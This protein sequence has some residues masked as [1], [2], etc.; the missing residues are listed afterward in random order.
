MQDMTRKLRYLFLLLLLGVTGNAFAQVGELYGTILDA[1]KQPA[2]GAIITVEQGGINKGG[3]PADIDGNFSIKP[4]QAGRYDVKVQYAGHQTVTTQGVV[5]NADHATKLSLNLQSSTT[6]KEVVVKYVRPIIDV[7][8]PGANNI[9]DRETIKN[10]PTRNTA[11]IAATSTGVYQAKS[12]AGLSIAG[13]R[14]QGTLYVIDGVQVNG[15]NFINQAPDVI[16]QMEVLTS[17]IPA[18]YGDASGGVIKITTRGV[19]KEIRGGVTAEHS[20]DGYDNNYVAFNLSGPFATRKVNDIKKPI[21]GFFLAGDYRQYKDNDPSYEKNYV[22]KGDKLADLQQHPL[23]AVSSPTGIPVLNPAADYITTGDMEQQKARVNASG[24]RATLTGKLDYE[25]TP[26]TNITAGGSFAY[27][28]AYNYNRYYTMFAPDAISKGNSYT[29]RGYVRFTQRLGKPATGSTDN[30]NKI[31]NAYYSVQA[32]YQRDYTSSEDPNH[33]RNAFDYGYVGKFVENVTPQYAPGYDTATSPDRYGI[34]LLGYQADGVSFTPSNVNPYLSNYTSQYYALGGANPPSLANIPSN[35]AY[36]RNGDAPLPVYSLWGNVGSYISGYSYARADQFSLSVDASFDYKHNKTTHAIEFGLY[37]QQRAERSYGYGGNIWAVM[38]QLTSAAVNNNLD[39]SNPIFVVNGQHY[40]KADVNNGVVVPGP[41]DTILYNRA[42]NGS[43]SIN[44]GFDYNLRKKLG[45]DVHG[46]DYIQPDAM[47]PSMFSLGMFT[48]DELLNSGKSLV[49]YYGYDYTGNILNGQVNFNDFWKAKDANGMYTRPIGAYRPNY[50]AGYISDYI[51]FKDISLT[52]GVRIERFDNN[53]KVLKDPY[54]LYPT[55]NVGQVLAGTGINGSPSP[56]IGSSAPGG[57]G[58]GYVVYVDDNSSSKPTV[59]GYR[60]GDTWYD[61]S[62][63]E[64]S[65]PTILKNESGRD[66]QPYLQKTATGGVAPKITDN[67]FDPTGSFT[68]YTPQVNVMPRISFSFPINDVGQ[69]YAHY[70]VIMQRPKPGLNGTLSGVGAYASPV[71]YFYLQQNAANIIGN[72][73]LKP[74]KLIDYEVGFQQKL[75]DI[76]AITLNAFYKERQDQIQVRP[77]LYAY[78][79]TYYTY[80]NRD[81]S[82]SKGLGVK[83]E[84]RRTNHLAMTLSYTLQFAEGTGSSAASANGGNAGTVSSG[85]LLQNLISAQLPNLMFVTPLDYDSRHNIAANVD[86]R[87]GQGEGPEVGGLKVLQNAG[88]NLLF[89]A[90]SGEPYTRYAQ[91]QSIQNGIANSNLIQGGVNGNRLPWHYMMNL[92]VDK[93]FALSFNN[94][95]GDEAAATAKRKPYYINA[96]VMINNLLNTRDVLGV[97][98]YTGRAD[99]DGYLTSAQGISATAQQVNAKSFTDLYSVSMQN[100]GYLNNP[101]RII[102]G[103]QFNF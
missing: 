41:N 82:T 69:I 92:K 50:I 44:G 59:T 60:S 85:G 87:Y 77:Y 65:D 51:R 62:G 20:V 66:L 68:D 2:T 90:R 83:Y 80:G 12:G 102:L 63:R 31:T 19:S 96:Y 3:A 30:N 10:M 61:A 6:L 100:P 33:K 36:L 34:R 97:Y 55:Y 86:Y 8:K 64:V 42:Y 22:L 38:R 5:I 94:K 21:V 103:L 15:S 39:Y 43:D 18:K 47:D 88:V 48:P 78:P 32:D 14:S 11:D 91:P 53:T 40:T 71:D 37:Y 46:H 81:F 67:N 70:D 9:I 45:L 25:V 79:T 35:G 76:S 101:R 56:I 54:S 93:D 29:G 13:A 58:N 57:I 4:L 99:D 72:P 28:N 26:G 23:V 98:S 95:K 24:S 7:A 16:D 49:S 17:G 84:L 75:S 1:T 74:E 89:T 73:D 27:T 52:L